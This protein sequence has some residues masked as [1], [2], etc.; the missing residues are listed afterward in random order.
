MGPEPQN[1]AKKII[2]MET[3]EINVKVGNHI[4]FIFVHHIFTLF[5]HLWGST[6]AAGQAP[7]ALGPGPGLRA[8]KCENNMKN[9]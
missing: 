3:C 9:I 1:V 8:P 7:A 4:I 2:Y 5:A 6:A